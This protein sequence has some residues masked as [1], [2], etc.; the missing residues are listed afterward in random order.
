MWS[1]A[2]TVAA[3][4]I[5]MTAVHPR[6][7]D[8]GQ[9]DQQ[10]PVPM[11]Y[12]VDAHRGGSALNTIVSLGVAL[13]IINAT[14]AIIAAG[15]ADLLQLR[16]GPRVAGPGQRLDDLRSQFSHRGR[17]RDRRHRCGAVLCR[18]SR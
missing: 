8:L 18:P 5:P 15:R 13:A 10:P 3:E 12:F 1:L 11:E 6:R 2:I 14:V 4:L 7:A 9:A 17:D 16:P